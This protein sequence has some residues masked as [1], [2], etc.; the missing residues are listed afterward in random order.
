F[1]VRG[2]VGCHRYEGYDREADA[3]SNA[4]QSIKTLTLERDERRREADQTGKAADVAESDEEAQDL[5]KRVAALKQMISQIEGRIDEFEIESKLL[6]QDQ[7]KV[8]PNLKEIKAKLR[9]A[10]LPVWLADPQ[11]FR[12][13]TKMPT[14]R[15]DGDEV[16]AISA[17]IWQSALEVKLPP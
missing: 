13:G 14:F 3:L 11:A 1:Q 2:C 6:M 16:K 12:P 10:W 9:R 5:R 17:F 7:K 4:R 8:G 15:L